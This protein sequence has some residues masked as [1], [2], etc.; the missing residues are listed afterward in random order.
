MRQAESIRMLFLG[1]HRSYSLAHAA[2]LIGWP[3]KRLRSELSAQYLVPEQT[4]DVKQV[5]WRQSLF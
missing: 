4:W 5:P 1:G 3:V 2:A